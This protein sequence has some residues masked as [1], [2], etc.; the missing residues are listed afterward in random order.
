VGC[1]GSFPGPDSPASCYLVE[2]DDAKVLLDMGNGSLGALANYINVYDVDAVLLSH[3]H[4]DHC[5]DLCS[6]YVAR[7]YCPEGP[8]PV[9]P[10][11]GPSGTAERLARAYDLA[12]GEDML[13]YFDFRTWDAGTSYDIG[14]LRVTVDRVNHP[15][16][17]YGMRLE[18]EGRTLAYSGDTDETEA[19]T[20]LASG[21]DLFLCEAAFHE[22]RDEGVDGVHLTGCTAGR[23]A[24]AAKAR[25]LVLTHIPP[26]ND[27]DRTLAEARSTYAG[28]IELARAGSTY[29][30]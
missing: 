11:Y 7:K 23:Q 30:V 24:T 3:L 29:D 17:A 1:S 28:P 16:E 5:I 15:V 2:T 22:G 26:W 8:F 9:V 12:P 10:V 14:A 19:L 27:P 6:Y 25:R 4:P 13:P 21:A 18:H 20:G